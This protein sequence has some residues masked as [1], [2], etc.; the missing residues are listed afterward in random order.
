MP[1]SDTNAS[2]AVWLSENITRSCT[3]ICCRIRSS[4]YLRLEN[5]RFFAQVETLSA[6]NNICIPR[7][8]HILV[9]VENNIFS[10]FIVL[11]GF[12]PNIIWR[13]V[14]R[15][16]LKFLLKSEQVSQMFEAIYVCVMYDVFLWLATEIKDFQ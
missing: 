7:H 16:L 10:L 5:D 14:L 2:S 3:D 4:L 8:P 1:S 13:R 9:C 15:Y 11:L 12:F 6:L